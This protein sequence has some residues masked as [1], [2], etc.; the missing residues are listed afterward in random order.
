MALPPMAAARAIWEFSRS[1]LRLDSW[2]EQVPLEEAL[3]GSGS[4]PDVPLR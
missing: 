3:E 1:G 4:T 2:D